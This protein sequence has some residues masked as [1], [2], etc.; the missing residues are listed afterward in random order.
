VE[1]AV[2]IPCYNEEIT[3]AKVV[4]DFKKELPK[5]KIYVFDN[6]SSD[7]TA[8]IALDNGAIV[9]KEIRQGKGNVVRTAFRIIDADIYVMID[10]DDTYPAEDV[11]ELLRPVINGTADV[12]VGDRHSCGKYE[13]ENKRP[14]HNFGNQLVKNLINTLFG[15]KLNDIMSGYRVFSRHFVKNCPI[16]SRGFEIETE[17]SLH[18]LDKNYIIQELPI[19]YR[20]RPEGSVSKLNTVRDGLRVLKTIFWLFKDYKPLVFF[21]SIALALCLSGL[22]LG[23]P[24]IIEFVR[25]G[26]VPR[27]PTAILATGIELVAVLTFFCGLILDTIAKYHRIDYE[28]RLNSPTTSR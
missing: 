22:A 13:A 8:Q 26:L 2:I 20:D 23:I 27:I 28:L 1:I 14:F 16:L 4:Q 10:G 17:L 25:T 15:A 5:A 24:I 18:T 9:I 21:S 19:N 12:V 3:I 6:N 11:H 7:K